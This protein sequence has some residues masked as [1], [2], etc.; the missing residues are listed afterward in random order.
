MRLIVRTPMMMVQCLAQSLMPV[1]IACVLGRDD[2]GRAVAFFSIF[3]VGILSGMFTI[4]A[5][6]VEECDDLLNM[7]PH[8]ARLFRYGKMVSGFLLPIGG[9]IVIGI[10]LAIFGEPIRRP[11]CCWRAIPLGLASSICG[12]DVCLAG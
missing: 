10:G 3:V 8:G 11:R 2:P 5:G 6:T 1:G 12:E 4:A 7:S 9:A